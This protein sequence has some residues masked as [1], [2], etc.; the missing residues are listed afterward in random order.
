MHKDTKEALE[1]LEAQLLEEER[2]QLTDEELDLLLE[3]FLEEDDSI[4]EAPGGYRNFA[5][6]Y[7][8]Y[9]ADDVDVELNTY[10]DEVYDEPQER[11]TGLL[12]AAL[13][14]LIGSAAALLFMVAQ[15]L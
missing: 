10:S 6:G 9:N 15:M 5:N 7:Q 3:D 2:P 11:N 13:I 4:G 8:A 1:R 14:S 12:A